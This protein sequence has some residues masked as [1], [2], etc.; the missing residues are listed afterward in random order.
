VVGAAVEGNNVLPVLHNLLRYQFHINWEAVTAGSLP[1][2][3]ANPA[4]ANFVET[5]SWLLWNLVTAEGDDKRR[6]IVWLESL[7]ELLGEDSS[8]HLSASIGGN[9][10]DKDVV[11]ETLEG[12][13]AGEAKDTAFLGLVSILPRRKERIEDFYDYQTYR[14]SIVGLSKVSIDTTG[15][16]GVNDT[17]ILLL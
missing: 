15:G 1:S 10:V 4:A 8:C 17:S 9:S 13:S 7:N 16:G 14:S 2:G 12:K 6:D 11:L 3:L 5:S